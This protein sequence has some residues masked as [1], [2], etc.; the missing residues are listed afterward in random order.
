MDDQTKEFLLIMRKE[1]RE[2]FREFKR[3]LE[4]RL[5]EG[6]KRMGELRSDIQRVE[7]KVD[8][9]ARLMAMRKCMA[10]AGTCAV[11]ELPKPMPIIEVDWGKLRK[12]GVSIAAVIWA[13]IYSL[14]NY[15]HP[16]A[17]VH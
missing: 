2:N 5:S 6:Q 14:W 15:F 8:T 16:A 12:I 4:D 3:G 11:D 17:P 13:L 10:P 9:N 1:D 7:V